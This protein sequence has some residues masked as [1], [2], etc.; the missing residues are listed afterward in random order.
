MAVP[1]S[2]GLLMYRRNGNSIQA[3]LIHPGGPYFR[4]KDIGVWSIPKGMI[5][6]GEELLAAALREFEEETGIIPS[7]E[8]IPLTPVRMSSGK[9]VHA[10]AFEGEA[11]PDRV[12]SN[13]FTLEWPPRSGRLR[14]YPEVDRAGWFDLDEAEMRITRGQIPLITELRELLG[15]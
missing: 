9:V 12:T 11:D 3:F 14:E 13:T 6:P 1:V 10:W 7:G 5:A 4:N 2:A 8:Y 15:C